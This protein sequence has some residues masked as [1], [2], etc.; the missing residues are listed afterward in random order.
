MSCSPA[1]HSRESGNPAFAFAC[2]GFKSKGFHSPCRRA[3]SF[4]CSCK[5]RNQRNTPQRLAP[6][7]HPARKVRVIG[8]VPLTAHPCAGSGIDA[9][10]RADPTGL[11]VRCRRKAM[12]PRE[13][14]S[15]RVLRAEAKSE[16]RKQSRF[17]SCRCSWSWAPSAAARSG[18]SRP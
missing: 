1:R 6:F 7:G 11:F 16:R 9:I 14:Q 17:C 15:A 8:R 2:L 5:E 4:L 13:E 3:G 12:G 10:P 18:R